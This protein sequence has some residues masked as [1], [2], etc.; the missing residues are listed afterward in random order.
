MKIFMLTDSMDI[1]G[2]ETHVFELSRLLTCRGH[3]VAVLSAGGRM[4]EAL[5]EV[6]VRH[7]LLP[8]T[9]SPAALSA[10][11]SHIRREKPHMV[12]AHTRRCAFLCRL[13][14]P[15]MSF[16]FTVTAHAMFSHTAPKDKL[17]FFPPSTIAVSKDIRQALIHR[18]S[19]PRDSITVIPNGIDTYR[20]RP[21]PDVADEPLILTVSRLD[22]DCAHTVRLLCAALPALCRI[23]GKPWRLMAVG[24][25]NALPDIIPIARKINSSLG[26]EAVIL[27]GARTDIPELLARCRVFVGVSRAALEAMAMAKPVI[28]SGDEGYLGLLDQ[29]TMSE[30]IRSNFCA[31][32]HEPATRE[33]LLRDLLRLDGAAPA[34]RAFLGALGRRMIRQSYTAEHMAE[35]TLKVYAR[36]Q[37]RHRAALRSDAL[38]CGYYGYGNCG[39][40]LVLRHMIDNQQTLSPNL[41]LAVLTAQGQSAHG[42]R[43]VPRYRPTAVLREIRHCGTF[44]LG[45]GSLLQDATSRR[46]LAYY[47]TLLSL[48]H[49][50]AVPT[51]LYANGLG[52]LTPASL[53]RCRRLLSS[54][55]II[56]LRDTASYRLVRAMNLPNTKVILGADPVLSRPSLPAATAPFIAFLPKAAANQQTEKATVFAVADIAIQNHLHV[57]LAPMSR[58]EDTIAVRRAADLLRPLLAPHALR[59]T[60]SSSAPRAIEKLIARATLVVSGRLHALILAFRAA[61]PCVGIGNDPKIP[62]FLR[63]ANLPFAY[64]PAPTSLPSSV[65]YAL[66]HPPA[67]SRIASLRA[68]ALAD[69]QVANELILRF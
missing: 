7:I 35:Q 2:A 58:A 5:S 37:K 56:S 12:H 6:G 34:E 40:E 28:L 50:C 31:R 54:V 30:G 25:G 65:R 17:S 68:R 19:V 57:T 49:A 20:F 45:G 4:A 14:L 26:R 46:S 8:D 32:G 10:V 22:T 39:D 38:I 24:G 69:A 42:I 15:H 52:P 67:P 63:D 23:S 61:V 43:G 18:F 48:A 1:G 29:Q 21:R 3:E 33:R 59:V 9:A 36:E 62:S 64:A 53:A 47:L 55:D 44:I 60:V 16:P 11:A 27:P 13:L 66:L 51:M 41:R